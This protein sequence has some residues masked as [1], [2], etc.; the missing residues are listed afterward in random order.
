MNSVIKR[1]E[2]L[3]RACGII[4]GVGFVIVNQHHKKI[5]L[6]LSKTSKINSLKT[7]KNYI[8]RQ[9]IRLNSSNA[10]AA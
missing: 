7:Q 2:E 6:R 9:K 4:G 1:E 8:L 10:V 5:G 3:K